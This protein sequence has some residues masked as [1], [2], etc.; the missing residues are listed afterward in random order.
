MNYGT[1]LTAPRLTFIKANW[2]ISKA[3]VV[4][5]LLEECV[6]VSHVCFHLLVFAQTKMTH[7]IFFMM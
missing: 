7:A 4:P 6:C 1:D 5:S 2:S 3:T